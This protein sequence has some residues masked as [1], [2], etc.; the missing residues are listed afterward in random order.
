M[1]LAVYN[2]A[3][4][5]TASGLALAPN[6]TVEVR[7]ESDSGLA[8]LFSDEA[9]T[10]GI[11]NPSAFA[12]SEG[13]FA[14]YVVSS[15]GGY[16]IKV[17]SGAENYTLNNVAIGTSAQ[18][19]VGALPPKSDSTSIVEGSSDDTKEL[20]IEVDG[21]TTATT[22]VW[23]APDADLTVVGEDT[24]QTLTNKAIPIINSAAD[25]TPP[26]FNDAGASREIIQGC[27]AWAKITGTGTPAAD[28]NFNVA[29][30]TDNATGDFDVNFSTALPNANYAVAGSAKESDTATGQVTCLSYYKT[31]TVAGAVNIVV[32]NVA[33]GLAD[34]V[35]VSVVVF[36]NP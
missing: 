36:A 13:R 16:S 7:R 26:V 24:A 4:F 18:Y 29:S 14:F 15:I 34:P 19:D 27:W 6:A 25:E 3:A 22:R 9:G 32:S 21:L 23:T 28:D 11:T 30:I 8:G 2:S 10:I 35:T 12:D 17:T 33:Q 20:R 5:K 31:A 1:T